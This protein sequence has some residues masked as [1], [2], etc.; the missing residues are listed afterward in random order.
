M[1]NGGEVHGWNITVVE[2]ECGGMD[3]CGVDV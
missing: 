1:I 3:V 2:Y